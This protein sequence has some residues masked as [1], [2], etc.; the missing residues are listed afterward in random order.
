[1]EVMLRID[2]AATAEMMRDYVEGEIGDS[3]AITSEVH[4]ERDTFLQRTIWAIS[5]FLVTSMDYTV[6]RRLNLPLR[7]DD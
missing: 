1:M 3:R 6:S 5:N 4:A 7:G 2:D